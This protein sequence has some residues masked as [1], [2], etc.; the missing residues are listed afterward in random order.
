[1]VFDVNVRQ[2]NLEKNLKRRQSSIERTTSATPLKSDKDT[3]VAKNIT[4]PEKK[5]GSITKSQKLQFSISQSNK[6]NIRELSKRKE[7]KD[8]DRL[9]AKKEESWYTSR[10]TFI[11]SNNY[12]FERD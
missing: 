5:L 10:I 2:K 11:P 9:S 4:S 1:M 7:D 3:I 6:K 8:L 12:L